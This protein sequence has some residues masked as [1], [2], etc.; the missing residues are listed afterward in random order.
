VGSHEWE[1]FDAEVE[2]RPLPRDNG[3]TDTYVTDHWPNY[4]GASFRFFDRATQRWSI[5]WASNR[6]G[7][8]EPPVWGGFDAAG[9]GVFEGEDRLDGKPIRVRYTW[10]RTR[11]DSPRWEQAFSADGGKTWETNWRMDFDRLA[12]GTPGAAP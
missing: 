11:T 4:A 6:S 8:L 7:V 5:Y 1:D 9:I 2:C 12:G 10:S 3:N